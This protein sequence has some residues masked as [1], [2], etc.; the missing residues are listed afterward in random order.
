MSDSNLQIVETT[1]QTFETD[2]MTRSQLGLVVVDFWA[3]WCAPCRMLGPILEKLAEEFKGRFTLVKA[4]TEK[5]PIAAR[6]FSVAGIPAVFAMLDEKVIDSFQGVLPEENAREWIERCLK[7]EELFRA[8]QL[9]ASDPEQ[10]ETKLRELLAD[11]AGDEARVAL[12]E[13]LHQQGKKEA[14]RDLLVELEK[15]GF[16]EPECEKIKSE[17]ELQ[18]H[19]DVDIS[20]LLSKAEASPE[21]LPLQFELAEALAAQAKYEQ[22]FAI[23]LDLLAKDRNN[24][25]EQGRQLM[26]DIFRVL[27][28]DSELTREY[29]RKLSMAL[30]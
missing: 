23:C 18:S 3:E 15:R 11:G 13:V 29:R 5:T 10:A 20:A 7:A 12:L 27:G 22:A 8:R 25:G 21:D 16:L 4:D 28:D 1:D 6:N 14:V 2:V 19:S 30:Y 24:L 9:V 26:V 17:L